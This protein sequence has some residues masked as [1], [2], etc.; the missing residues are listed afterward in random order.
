MNGLGWLLKPL[1]GRDRAAG[2]FVGGKGVR[3]TGTVTLL[4]ASCIVHVTDLCMCDGD[5]PLL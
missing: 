1:S 5:I 4:T 3:R 2:R